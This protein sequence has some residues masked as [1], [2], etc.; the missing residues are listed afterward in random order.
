MQIPE[1]LKPALYGAVAGAIAISIAGF[2]WGGWV[3]GGSAQKMATDQARLEVVAALVPVCVE[4]SRLDPNAVATLASLKGESSFKRNDML[5]QTGWATMPGATDP[6]KN[7]A[8]AC[9]DKLAEQF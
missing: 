9:M 1:W 5:M 3:T 2:S 6:D 7:V 8:K 4:Q